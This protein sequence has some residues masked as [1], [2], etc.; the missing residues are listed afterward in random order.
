MCEALGL[1]Q[2]M[3]EKSVKICYK[4]CILDSSQVI[5]IRSLK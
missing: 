4:Q 3:A 2:S 5:Y 1:L